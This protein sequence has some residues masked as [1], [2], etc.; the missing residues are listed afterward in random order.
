MQLNIPDE[1]L[2]ELLH[3]FVG[4]LLLRFDAGLCNDPDDRQ[5]R[6]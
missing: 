3:G 4:R 5:G 6:V 2:L 1:L